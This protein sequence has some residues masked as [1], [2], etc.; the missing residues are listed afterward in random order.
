MGA[1][2]STFI[3][4]PGASA[5]FAGYLIRDWRLAGAISSIALAVIILL[6]WLQPPMSIFALPFSV[7]VAAGSAVLAAY[8]AYRPEAGVWDRMLVATVAAVLV[9]AAILYTLAGAGSSVE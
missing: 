4:A 2:Y 8:L 9:G 7:G 3:L 1:I 6:M 5:A